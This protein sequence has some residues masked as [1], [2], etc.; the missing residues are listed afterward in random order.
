[1]MKAWMRMA[2]AMAA[3]GIASATVQTY[4]GTSEVLE[5]ATTINGTTQWANFTNDAIAKVQITSDDLINL[6][7]GNDL[8]TPVPKNL[9]LAIAAQCPGDD[10]RIIVWD[11]DTDSNLATVADMQATSVI[12][13]VKKHQHSRDIVSQMTFHFTP[14]QTNGLSGGYAFAQGVIQDTT[15]SCVKSYRADLIGALGASFFFTNVVITNVLDVTVTNITTNT[16]FVVSNF[17]VNVS[18]TSI[19]TKGKSLGT[20]I[21]P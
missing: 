12:R 15:N 7:L 17:T 1:M 20:L 18:N 3:V 16:T 2:A 10:M 6:G 8:A 9:K 13:G 21:E 19:A 11:T 4:G 14:T 5:V